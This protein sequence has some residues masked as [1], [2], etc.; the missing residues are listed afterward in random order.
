MA[1][2]RP[3]QVRRR[4]RRRLRAQR[5]R[6]HVVLKRLAD[7]LAD[8]DRD[9]CGDPRQRRQQ[10]RPEQRLARHARV[11]AG[12]REAA[13][14]GAYAHAGVDAGAASATS[15][16]TAPGRA[17]ATRSRSAAL[18]AVLGA[19]A[20][21][22]QRR[23]CVGSVKTNIGHTEGAAGVA[24]LIKAALCAVTTASSHRACTSTNPTRPSPGR[25]LPLRIPTRAA[26]RG[27]RGAPAAS[28]ASARSASPAPTP[29]SCSS[30]SSP[31]PRARRDDLGGPRGDRP[32]C[33]CR[34]VQ[35]QAL[36]AL[37]AALSQLL[38][39][40]RRGRRSTTSAGPPRP[41][42]PRSTDRAPVR[43]AAM[44]LRSVAQLPQY[45]PSSGRQRSAAPSTPRRARGSLRGPGAG[46]AV[47]RHGAGSCFATEPAFAAALA[48]VR[49][50]AR[51]RFST[52]DRRTAGAV[53]RRPRYRLDRI[54]V[55]QPA[56]MALAIGYAALWRDAGASNRGCRRPQHGRGRR[57]APGAARSISSRR[58]ASSAA[59]AR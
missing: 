5:R 54:D 45:R 6:R 41:A 1:P 30:D 51:P 34:R 10:R 29:M 50:S 4:P 32:C 14:Q 35:L 38:V 36:Q 8:G 22:G 52:V 28:P 47:A 55:V 15:R 16:R 9:L 17:P 49:R 58:C 13:A 46:R 48:R 3:L 23:A 59:A 24:G 21:A 33:R 20:A 27:R 25:D 53:H 11:R 40:S 56:L 44:P 42:A 43:R 7:A 39:E 57:G 31:R 37:A 18:G 2:R 19:E 26:C 12:Q